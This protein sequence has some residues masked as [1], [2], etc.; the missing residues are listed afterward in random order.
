MTKVSEEEFYSELSYVHYTK[1][2]RCEESTVTQYYSPRNEVI[3]TIY[4][5]FGIGVEYRLRS[6]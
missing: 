2:V 5:R 4:E 1:F 6:V 3:G